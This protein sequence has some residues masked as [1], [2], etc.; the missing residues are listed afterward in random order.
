M[1]IEEGAEGGRMVRRRRRK[2][3][4]NL[5]EV[6]EDSRVVREGKDGGGRS[7]GWKE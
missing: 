2:P 3:N 6:V 1:Y 5:L 4:I 7:K